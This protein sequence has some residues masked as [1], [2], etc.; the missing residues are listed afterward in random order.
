MLGFGEGL[1][2]ATG[3]LALLVLPI[4]SRA[5]SS[6]APGWRIIPYA[7][8][9]AFDDTDAV[10]FASGFAGLSLGSIVGIEADF[11]AP[12]PFLGFRVGAERTFG[13]ELFG[14]GSVADADVRSVFLDARVQ[15]VRRSWAVRPFL[16]VGAERLEFSFENARDFPFDV[17][18]KSQVATR[19]GY[20]VDLDILGGSFRME[21][22][23]RRYTAD[24]AR[25]L[26][27]SVEIFEPLQNINFALVAGLRI[28]V[29]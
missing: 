13:S 21:A 16:F 23:H 6:D 8:E 15:P 27:E 7:G 5:Q 26:G 3:F 1:R 2:I 10:D 20:G 11:D 29:R 12:V 24:E 28:G 9:Y 22:I 19:L 17:G 14:S 4:T 25:V 18:S